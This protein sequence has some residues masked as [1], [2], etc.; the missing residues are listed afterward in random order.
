[1]VV[2]FEALEGGKKRVMSLYWRMRAEFRRQVMRSY[3]KQHSF[4]YD[5]FS[6]ARNFDDGVSSH[7]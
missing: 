5:P 4:H 2:G 3:K 7:F 1:M 6:Y